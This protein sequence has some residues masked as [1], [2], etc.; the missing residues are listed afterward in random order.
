MDILSFVGIRLK[1]LQCGE[2]YDVPL[3]DVLLSHEM[4]MHHGCPVFPEETECPPVV[5]SRLFSREA[6]EALEAAWGR[7]ETRA[8]GD[9]GQLVLMTAKSCSPES[10]AAAS[11]VVGRTKL[12]KARTS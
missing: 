2:P 1:C 9:G 11:K 10:R 8:E 3:R 6:V 7:L 5:E 12:P 4:I